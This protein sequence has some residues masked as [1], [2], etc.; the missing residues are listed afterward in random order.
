MNESEVKVLA[1]EGRFLGQLLQGE[2]EE[3]HISWVILTGKYAFKIKKPVKLS[4]L[5]FSTLAKRKTYCLREL[6]L[7]QRFSPIYLN[8]LPIQHHDDYGWAIGY[9]KGKTV[10][11][12]VQMKKLMMSKR[13]DKVLKRKKVTHDNIITLAKL[14]ASFHAEADIIKAPFRLSTPKAAFNDIRTTINLCKRHLGNEYAVIIKD[15]L[16]WSNS[17]LKTHARRMK[18]RIEE[19][20]IRDVHGDLH[21][22]NI[23]LYRTP[24][25]FD[26]IE[27][28]DAYRRI[29]VISEI[30][31]FCM[32]LDAHG[33]PALA[34]LFLKEY[35]RQFTCFQRPE[36]KKL[37]LY[38][39]CFRANVRAKVHALAADQAN[40]TVDYHHHIKAWKSYVNLM[41]TYFKTVS[42]LGLAFLAPL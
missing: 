38:Y 9:G 11:Y 29:D 35:Q 10:D 30:A 34:R 31:F 41:Q 28:D 36:D 7:N 22:G 20:F 8:V 3:T 24:I 27:F 40:D 21:S 32:D 18:E 19:G 39:K 42:F 26:C 37:F 15:S 25:L 17:F 6:Q 12:A 1:R 33:K 16:E 4:F 5:D 2:I 13:M 14:I 23:F